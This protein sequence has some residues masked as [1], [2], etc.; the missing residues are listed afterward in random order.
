MGATTNQG[1]HLEDRLQPCGVGARRPSRIATSLPF[2]RHCPVGLPGL[3]FTQALGQQEEIA[4]DRL[5]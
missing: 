2:S 3:M 5:V 1:Y 4:K